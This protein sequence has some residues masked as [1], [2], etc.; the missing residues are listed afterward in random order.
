M[1]QPIG[2]SSVFIH[3]GEVR[4]CTYHS[5]T[6][7]LLDPDYDMPAVHNKSLS[8]MYIGDGST[9]LQS[10]LRTSANPH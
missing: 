1:T 2:I 9:V 8:S 5:G 4:F 3:P 7:Q 10:D 6:G